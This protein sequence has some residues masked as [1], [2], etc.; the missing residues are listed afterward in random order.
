MHRQIV[1]NRIYNMHLENTQGEFPLS[2]D[3]FS[4]K[5]I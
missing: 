3:H 1:H 2:I 5:Q 4:L